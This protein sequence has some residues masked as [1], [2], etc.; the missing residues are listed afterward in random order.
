MLPPSLLT[1]AYTSNPR[2]ARLL[3]PA[4]RLS[5]SPHTVICPYFCAKYALN[6]VSCA[7]KSLLAICWRR[8]LHLP[9]GTSSSLRFLLKDSTL[10]IRMFLLR[11]PVALSPILAAPR[12]PEGHTLGSRIVCEPPPLL[13]P[14]TSVYD[15]S[16]KRRQARK[17]VVPF[18]GQARQIRR[19]GRSP[20]EAM[21]RLRPIFYS[22]TESSSSLACHGE[23]AG[24]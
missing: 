15:L 10:M 9:S 5:S 24:M 4:A 1:Y 17:G 6:T 8:R 23:F 19:N 7:S 2:C 12:S 16:S 14:H 3:G 18:R 13:V 20:W 21:S 22:D 11:T